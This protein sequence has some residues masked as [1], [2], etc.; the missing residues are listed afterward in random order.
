MTSRALPAHT[1]LGWL[2]SLSIDVRA[3]VVLD[4][5][6]AVLAGDEALAARAA[7]ALAAAAPGTLE[8]RADGLLAV[9]SSRHAVAAEV[10]PRALPGLHLADLHAVLAALD[11]D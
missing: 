2:R 8:I 11:A 7:A 6:G 1:A 9:R 10:G 5:D 3:A 4:G